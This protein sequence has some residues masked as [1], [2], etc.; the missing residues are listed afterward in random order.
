MKTTLYA[1]NE[2]LQMLNDVR[3]DLSD[4][5]KYFTKSEGTRGELQEYINKIGIKVTEDVK[6]HDAKH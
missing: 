2:K 6:E 4:H 5:K 3:Q 1:L